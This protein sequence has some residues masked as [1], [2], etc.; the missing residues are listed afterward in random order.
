MINTVAIALGGNV[1]R[2]QQIFARALAALDALPSIQLISR[3]RNFTTLPIGE[4]AGGEFINSVA[5][6]QAACTPQELLCHLQQVENEFGR[7]RTVHWGPRTLDLDLLSFGHEV[8]QLDAGQP[9]LTPLD[10]D[11]HRP[12]ESYRG[13]LVVPHPACWYRRFVL[14]PWCDV[15][16]HWRHPLLGETVRGLHDRLLRRPLTVA[17]LGRPEA[18]VDGLTAGLEADD[19]AAQITLTTQPSRD[20]DIT[21]VFESQVTSGSPQSEHPARSVC[22]KDNVE[23]VQLAL[24]VLRAALDQPIPCSD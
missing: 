23:G 4:S 11:V 21:L 20:A 24:Q 8:I 14:D 6:L 3:S 17:V 1:G 9:D 7:A 12:M 13:T 22:L 10:P 19:L 18:A 2:V 5:L 15:A 16:P